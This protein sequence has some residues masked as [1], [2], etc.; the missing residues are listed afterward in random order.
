MSQ[1]RVLVEVATV[2]AFQ[3]TA[4]QSMASNTIGPTP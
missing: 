3:Q 4:P 1:H 2:Q